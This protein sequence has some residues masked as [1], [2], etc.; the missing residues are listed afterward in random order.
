VI[1]FRREYDLAG[2]FGNRG[3]GKTT[4]LVKRL[5]SEADEGKEYDEFGANIHIKDRRIP[6]YTYEEVQTLQRKAPHGKPRF[7]LGLDQMH[8]LFD[9]RASGTKQNRSF[10]NVIIQS[11]QHG[12]DVLYDTWMSSAIDLRLRRF[13]PLMILAEKVPQGFSYKFV[14]TEAGPIG[15]RLMTFQYAKQNVFPYFDTSELVTLAAE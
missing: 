14:D 10:S 6:Y 13:T 11:R 3:N 15:M 7:L 5:R 8:L 9:S 12:F 4:Y 1:F 2:I